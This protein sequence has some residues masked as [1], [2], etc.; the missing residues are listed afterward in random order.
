MKGDEEAD[1]RESA[2]RLVAA[3]VATA[4]DLMRLIEGIA[5]AAM[6][7]DTMANARALIELDRIAR[8]LK[9][10]RKVKRRALIEQTQRVGNRTSPTG[11]GA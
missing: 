9:A 1:P 8:S 2:D 10:N 6:T 11:G 4:D 5:Y 7:A 3:I